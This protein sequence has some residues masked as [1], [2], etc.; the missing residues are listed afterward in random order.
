VEG[1]PA[2]GKGRL[3]LTEGRVLAADGAV[4]ASATGKYMPM[5]DGQLA[6]CAEDFVG[7]PAALDP[8]DLM[9]RGGAAQRGEAP[10]A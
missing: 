9:A 8:L 5:P 10:P 3:V 7:D 4:V 2:G 6:L 1:R